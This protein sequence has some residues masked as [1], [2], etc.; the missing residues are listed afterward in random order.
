MPRRAESRRRPRGRLPRDRRPSGEPLP[1][2]LRCA[3]SMVA[4]LPPASTRPPRDA[5]DSLGYRE[6]VIESEDR[7]LA[8][9]WYLIAGQGVAAGGRGRAEPTTRLR[10]IP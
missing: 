7:P 4:S 8:A 1:R 10:R 6:V 2:R 9:G 3:G 5:V